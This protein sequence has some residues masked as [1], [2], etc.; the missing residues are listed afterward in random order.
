M[1]VGEV[2]GAH[3]DAPSGGQDEAREQVRDVVL[4]AVAAADQGHMRGRRD[5]ERRAIDAVDQIPLGEYLFGFRSDTNRQHSR[6]LQSQN[7]HSK[8]P[9]LRAVSF[10]HENGV[11]WICDLNAAPS[12]FMPVDAGL[13]TTFEAAL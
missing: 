2:G 3:G 4:A 11:E 12:G 7:G 10:E 1:D 5:R 13:A 6:K 9:M 8:S